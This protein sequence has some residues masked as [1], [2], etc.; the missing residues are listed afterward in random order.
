MAEN[1][2]DPILAHAPYTLNMAAAK[3]EIFDFAKR[4]FRE[5]LERLEELL[6]SMY[7]FH[8]GSTINNGKEWGDLIRL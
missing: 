2:F 8:L 1:Y 7:N 6:C 3:E 4:A 5:D